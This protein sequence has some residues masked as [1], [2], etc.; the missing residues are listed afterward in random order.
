M[1]SLKF[2]ALAS[3]M[4]LFLA[5]PALADGL[6]SIPSLA[7][8]PESERVQ[9]VDDALTLGAPPVRRPPLPAA[10]KPSAAPSESRAVG[11]LA[12]ATAA[13]PAPA[14]TP[15]APSSRP[16]A[17]AAV[18]TSADPAA[19]IAR[20]QREV[21]QAQAAAEA[22]ASRPPPNQ[23]TVKSGR[24]E[25][26]SIAGQGQLNRLVTPF[27]RPYVRTTALGTTTFVEGG[28]IYVAT[29]TTDPVSL[30]I[31]DEGDE[32][33]AI[34]LTLKPRDIPSVQVTLSLD[35]YRPTVLR[36]ASVDQ[37][38]A[39]EA[40]Q[41]HTETLR[42]V[43]KSLAMG[44]VPPGYGITLIQPGTFTGVDC[45]IEGVQ[46]LPAQLVSG[47]T[48]QVVVSR[49]QNRSQ[50]PVEINES[51]CASDY[52][53]GVAAWPRTV[54]QPGEATELFIA[55]RRDAAPRGTARPSTLGGY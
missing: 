17:P 42:E 29:A 48:L 11:S 52:T 1:T 15:P 21:Q 27:A 50:W 14:A 46:V 38:Q 28:V 20:M 36:P 55:M 34:S 44:E 54:L 40:S 9:E 23:L 16:P 47:A 33:N 2:S 6:G 12:P 18:T 43:M 25:V 5:A 22:Q 49:V 37:A 13:T 32:V 35:G 3:A 4:A 24:N 51:M 45:L 10:S 31:M 8:I 30:F 7:P 39:F 41:P 53:L 19:E 26:L